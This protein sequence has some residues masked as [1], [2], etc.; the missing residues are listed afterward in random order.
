MHKTLNELNVSVKPL[1]GTIG[2]GSCTEE[3]QARCAARNAR[4]SA[5]FPVLYPFCHNSTENK[6]KNNKKREAQNKNNDKKELK[7]NKDIESSQLSGSQRKTA[8]ALEL[9]VKRF[10]DIHGFEN[11][12]MLT[13]TF[14]E[15]VRDFKE[16]QRRFNS[17]ATHYIRP[18]FG[19]YVCVVE[20]QER[21]AVHYH[22]VVN[23][24][25]DIRTGFDFDAVNDRNYR[26]VTGYLKKLWWK[27]REAAEKYGF[28]RTEIKP[29]IST[30]Q[31]VARYLAKY[32]SKNIAGHDDEDQLKGARVVRYSGGFRIANSQITLLNEYSF[33]WRQTLGVFGQ[34]EGLQYEDMTSRFGPR[35]AYHYHELL[36]LYEVEEPKHMTKEIASDIAYSLGFR[37]MFTRKVRNEKRE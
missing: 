28:G 13:L 1:L 21:G 6:E 33:K 5:P 10:C 30:E 27:T 29:I 16:A 36:K 9:N 15:N 22:L 12:G 37:Y 14:K 20:L 2:V 23:C 8:Y 7:N 31:G 17:M 3:K 18:Q 26:S 34:N 35:W 32:L 25:E 4:A 11:I 24:G 19:D